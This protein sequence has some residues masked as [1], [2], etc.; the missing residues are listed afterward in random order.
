MTAQEKCKQLR[1]LIIE[2]LT[3]L[4]DNNYVLWDLPYHANIGDQLIW[5][6]EEQFLRTLPYK[7]LERRSIHTYQKHDLDKNTVILLHGGGNFGDVWEHYEL[8]RKRI[9]QD[10]PENPIIL[11]PQTVHYDSLD[12]IAKDAEIYRSHKNLYIC[13]RDKRSYAFLQEHHF[14]SEERI[15]LLPD[16][17]FCINGEKLKKHATSNTK[18]VLFVNRI[19]K[20]NAGLDYSTSVPPTAEIHDWPPFENPDWIVKRLEWMRWKFGEHSPLVDLYAKHLY[21]PHLIRQGVRFLSSYEMIYST[22]L[23]VCILAVLLG[24]ELTLF[25]NSYGKNSTFYDT[26]IKDVDGI[27][28]FTT[29]KNEE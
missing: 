5:E 25:D 18:G 12:K 9:I 8:F 17:A 19:D 28:L 26:W 14:S 21:H 15:L 27:S 13:A 16:M 11:F 7:C 20:E 2:T 29:R 3:P 24:K 10:Y 4:I 22:R 1:Q 23:H 6:G